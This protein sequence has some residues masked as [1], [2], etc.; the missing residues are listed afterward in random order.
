[1]K[2]RILSIIVALA[3]FIGV[4]PTVTQPAWADNIS[5]VVDFETALRNVPD[6]GTLDIS[7]KI[8]SIGVESA[9][10]LL[11]FVIDKRVTIVSDG[12]GSLEVRRAG[13]LLEADVTFRN[14]S[15]GLANNNRNAIFANGYTLTMENV[16]GTSREINLFGGNAYKIVD[17]YTATPISDNTGTHGMIVLRGNNVKL[18]NVYA[19]SMNGS[20]DVPVTLDLGGNFAGT[21]YSC[22]ALQSTVDDT[23]WFDINYQPERP[24][25]N[26]YS[27]SVSDD[28]VIRLTDSSVTQVDGIA[29]G[30]FL[31]KNYASVIYS[32]QSRTNNLRLSSIKSL[33]VES[34]ILKPIELN[35]EIPVSVKNGATLD[36]SAVAVSDQNDGTFTLGDF[37]GGGT[38]VV[39]KDQHLNFSGSISGT[40]EFKTPDDNGS[41]LSDTSGPVLEGHNYIT[42]ANSSSDLFTFNPHSSQY[43]MTLVR[44]DNGIWTAI[45]G[46]DDISINITQQP[47]DVNLFYGNGGTLSVTAQ[48]SNPGRAISYQWYE[49][50]QDGDSLMTGETNS[51]LTIPAGKVKGVYQYYCKLT[52]G[53]IV[54]TSSTATVTI[55]DKTDVTGLLSI[56]QSD[57]TYG[58]NPADQASFSGTPSG[59]GSHFTYTYS[60]DDGRT[61]KSLEA[62]KNSYGFLPAGDYV[63]KAIYEDNTQKGEVTKNFRVAQKLL[64]VTMNLSGV[65]KPYDGNTKIVGTQPKISLVGAVSNEQPKLAEGITYTYDNENAGNN[66]TIHASNIILASDEVSKN[67]TVATIATAAGAVITK[68]IP[69]G[70]PKYTAITQSGKTL[71][72]A[73]LTVQGGTFSTAG[74]VAWEKADSTEVQA[75]I[76]YKWVFTPTDTANYQNLTG[77]VTPYAVITGGGSSGGGGGASSGGS[78][79]SGGGSSGSDSTSNDVVSETVQNPDGSTTTTTTDKKN[80]IVTDVTVAKDG[81]TTTVETKKDGTVTR[82]VKTDKGVVGT[83]IM[84]QNGIVTRVTATVPDSA[85]QVEDKV[86]LPVKVSASSDSKAALPVEINMSGA[87]TEVKVKI[88]VELV[89]PGTVAVI[90]KSD[91]TE[92]IVKNSVST[93]D[94]VTLAIKGDTKVKIVDNSKNFSDVPATSWAADA[95][96]FASGHQLFIGTSETTFSPDEPMTRGMLTVVLHNL[97]NNPEYI[98]DLSFEDVHKD[99]WYADA[100]QW[101]ATEG[102]VGGYGD[103][104]FGADDPVTREQLAVMLWRYASGPKSEHS[105]AGFTDAGQISDYARQAIAWANEEKI[106]NGNGDGILEPKGQATRAQLA[107]MLKNF[108]ESLVK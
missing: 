65:T 82:T 66:K 57:L 41:I 29:K 35:S 51:T 23:R 95:V 60:N 10:E 31:N 54:L 20:F 33:T 89:T 102:I 97:E 81:T 48:S 55:N 73:N 79:S 108:L 105:L 58:E 16:T 44:N 107:Q 91:G 62:L 80:G 5:N 59:T 42:A 15:L 28:V 19:G 61:Y 90:I 8:Y 53:G 52:Y 14:I 74:S 6:G 30:E 77:S 18:G 67:Y 25:L 38:I 85:A 63:V 24:R 93:G 34:G 88:P 43:A 47:K 11:P 3:V 2:K 99:S 22:G 1:M 46:S 32:S 21:V 92:E 75:N 9:N 104:R 13:L 78:S 101:A 26:Y 56:N 17:A 86:M 27:F 37:I 39:K 84:D 87:D 69:T 106:L 103:G 98:Y 4:M 94:G 96:A 100:V 40:T 70:V 71:A 68:A 45:A 36:L 64:N 49:V 83:T 72:D 7:G 76:A 50:S 12:S